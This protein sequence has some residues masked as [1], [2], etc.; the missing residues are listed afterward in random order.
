M[1]GQLNLGVELIKDGKQLETD[2]KVDY[3]LVATSKQANLTIR[4]QWNVPGNYN[5]YAD[6]IGSTASG[7]P[8]KQRKKVQDG[9]DQTMNLM[10]NPTIVHPTFAPPPVL[11]IVPTSPMVNPQPPLVL[12]AVPPPPMF[13]RPPIL[14][15]PPAPRTAP[16]FPFSFR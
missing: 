15:L 12:V 11:I 5:L 14:I 4:G 6:K 7:L 1:A 8:P 16:F 2:A 3:N 13:I 10:M 9:V